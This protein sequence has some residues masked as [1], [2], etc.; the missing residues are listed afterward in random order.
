M[1]ILRVAQRSGWIF[2]PSAAPQVPAS[3]RPQKPHTMPWQEAFPNPVASR[4]SSAEK[5]SVPTLQFTAS[6]GE[7]L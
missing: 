2:L 6:V 3:P 4:S 5:T 7:A 1:S